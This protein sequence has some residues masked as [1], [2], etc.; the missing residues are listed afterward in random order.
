MRFR[1]ELVGFIL[2]IITPCLLGG[3]KSVTMVALCQMTLISYPTCFQVPAIFK[4]H[5]RNA[6]FLIPRVSKSRPMGQT[7]N[8]TSHNAWQFH[9]LWFPVLR[10]S[11]STKSWIHDA[12]SLTPVEVGGSPECQ[13][14]PALQFPPSPL[15]VCIVDSDEVTTSAQVPVYPDRFPSSRGSPE[16]HWCPGFSSPCLISS[17]Y[18]FVGC[19]CRLGLFSSCLFLLQ[20][21][22]LQFLLQ[23][24]WMLSYQILFLLRQFLFPIHRPLF[25]LLTCQGP[26]SELLYRFFMVCYLCFFW[27]FLEDYS[28][29]NFV[30]LL[31]KE[32]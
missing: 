9:F 13:P 4:S 5:L 14:L 19:C 27:D 12:P 6:S 2:H 24:R 22:S 29:K 30:G 16:P 15:G 25:R 32:I 26:W 18:S 31:L 7:S 1:K 21:Q 11:L 10:W 23:T 3:P 28:W 8:H 20:S 17:C